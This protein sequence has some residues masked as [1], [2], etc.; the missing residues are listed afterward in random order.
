MV[1]EMPKSVLGLSTY[2]S[3]L[4]KCVLPVAKPPV[5]NRSLRSRALS[6]TS[7]PLNT[8]VCLPPKLSTKVT[9]LLVATPNFAG[10]MS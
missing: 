9:R 1:A 10:A 8:S 3:Q 5:T 4:L 2:A 7:T 6:A